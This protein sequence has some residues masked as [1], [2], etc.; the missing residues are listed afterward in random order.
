M[1]ERAIMDHRLAQFLSRGV[2]PGGASADVVR[3]AVVAECGGVGDGQVAQALLEPLRGISALGHHGGDESVGLGDGETGCVDEPL[4]DPRPLRR[5]RMPGL[6]VERADVQ[7]GVTL[8]TGEQLLLGL[9]AAVA[10]PYRPVVFGP[11]TVPQMPAAI[12]DRQGVADRDQGQHHDD[13]D[14]RPGSGLMSASKRCEWC[15]GLSQL[16]S[17]ALFTRLYASRNRSIDG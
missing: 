17:E 13:D 3:L 4:L 2:L 12:P 8:L 7:V 9:P 14:C 1:E 16:P 5:V 10:V 11:E 15:A 6:R